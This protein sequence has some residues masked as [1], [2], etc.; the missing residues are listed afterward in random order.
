MMCSF[1]G[2]PVAISDWQQATGTIFIVNQVE[3][4]TYWGK[5]G[6]LVAGGRPPEPA[7]PA[8]RA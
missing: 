8:A 4:L 3:D 6:A 2:S 5:A 7:L 1:P